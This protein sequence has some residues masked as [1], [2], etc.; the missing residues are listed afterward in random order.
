MRVK[1]WRCSSLVIK[2]PNISV[3][4]LL[5]P[6]LM[7]CQVLF[8][9][10]PPG[11]SVV[12]LS[13]WFHQCVSV[14]AQG[15]GKEA[16]LRSGQNQEFVP[17]AAAFLFRLP[18]PQIPSVPEPR[19]WQE[20][21]GN[22]RW[23]KRN[24]RLSLTFRT[25]P[26]H[27]FVHTHI[28]TQSAVGEWW[29]PINLCLNTYTDSE[30]FLKYSNHQSSFVMNPESILPWALERNVRTS[31]NSNNFIFPRR[32]PESEFNV[33]PIHYSFTTSGRSCLTSCDAH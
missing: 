6:G 22:I 15:L 30:K 26:H 14:W 25:R 1:V 13:L 29:T 5:A 20:N 7:L 33:A 2:T 16:V 23:G 24:W 8:H 9:L 3:F 17:R 19:Y 32:I 31:N 27:L 18:V 12:R 10:C 4:K 21:A 28:H 11:V